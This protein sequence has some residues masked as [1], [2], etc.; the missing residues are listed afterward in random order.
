MAI[1][2]R[3]AGLALLPSQDMLLH[4]HQLSLLQ[5]DGDGAAGGGRGEGRAGRG[6]CLQLGARGAGAPTRTR[7]CDGE[8]LQQAGLLQ[9]LAAGPGG[10]AGGG[11]FS[12]DS[13]FVYIR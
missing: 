7:R 3:G 8:A 4:R 9:G 5:M 12:S 10:G 13:H 1:Q 6:P 11:C 2:Q